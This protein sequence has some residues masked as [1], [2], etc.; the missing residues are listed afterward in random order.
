MNA[1]PVNTHNNKNH[2]Q[3]L[4]LS[5]IIPIKNEAEN[6]NFLRDEIDSVLQGFPYSWECIWIDDG[7]TDQS[8]TEIQRF[9][10]E[11]NH[12]QYLLLSQNYGQSAALYAG[13]C[14]ARGQMLATMDGDGQNDPN[15]IPNLVEYLCANGCDL[16]NGVRRN[17]RDSF[18]RRISSRIANGFRNWLTQE[19]ITDVGC[20]L[21][22]FRYECV[23]RITP[24]NG[25]HRFLPTLIRIRG[26]SNIAEVP[27]NHRPRTRGQTSY[28]IHNRLWVGIADSFAVRWMQKRAVSAEVKSRSPSLRDT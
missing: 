1:E 17:R 25:F 5:I 9:N 19:N 8:P 26:Y 3:D 12:H 11:D 20:S 27:V 28:G 4:D 23:T 18:I 15:D 7:S 6:V 24:F 22:V 2:R 14:H 13:F 10:R 21:R 16:V